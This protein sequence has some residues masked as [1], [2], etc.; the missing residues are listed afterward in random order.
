MGQGLGVMEVVEGAGTWTAG[1]SKKKIESVYRFV[2]N[3]EI[4]YVMDYCRYLQLGK[5]EVT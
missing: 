4:S 3:P 5:L 2:L 1:I